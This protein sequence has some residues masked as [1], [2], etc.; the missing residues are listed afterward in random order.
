[1]RYALLVAAA[2]A[3]AA[4]YGCGSHL[5]PET[6]DPPRV[7]VVAIGFEGQTD[8]FPYPG[9]I[10]PT[11]VRATVS[12]PSGQNARSWVPDPGAAEDLKSNAVGYSPPGP[13][14]RFAFALGDRMLNI[15]ASSA[16]VTSPGVQVIAAPWGGTLIVNP[17][18][19]ADEVWVEISVVFNDT[20]DGRPARIDA[21]YGF[22]LSRVGR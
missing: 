3:I 21:T 11:L 12:D 13:R 14:T 6:L 1:M 16:T 19:A 17:A 15:P 5:L 2:I 10:L 18:L 9:G 22:W 4:V 8:R 20:L 7:P